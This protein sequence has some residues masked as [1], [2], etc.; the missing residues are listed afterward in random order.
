MIRCTKLQYENMMLC[1][2]KIEYKAE[3]YSPTVKELELLNDRLDEAMP[4]LLWIR[5]TGTETS[6]NKDSREKVN[7]IINENLLIVD[8]EANLKCP[9]CNRKM[10]YLPEDEEYSCVCGFSI[11]LHVHGRYLSMQSLMQLTNKKHTN[12]I[13]FYD[14]GTYSGNLKIAHNEVILKVTPETY[15]CPLC[16][17]IFSHDSSSSSYSCESDKC[18]F[19]L[20]GVGNRLFDKRNVINLIGGKVINLSKVKIKGRVLDVSVRLCL[21]RSDEKYGKLVVRNQV[22][23]NSVI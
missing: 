18:G 16:G 19:R 4:Y 22:E 5:E 23:K 11:P 2:S 10:E 17:Y 3:E 6:E 13:T 20:K 7:K 14:N 12:S 15:K 8:P 1:F 21:D 9:Y